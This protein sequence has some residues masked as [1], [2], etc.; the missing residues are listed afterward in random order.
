MARDYAAFY[1]CLSA[2]FRR[3]PHLAAALRVANRV[4]EVIMYGAY[5]VMLTW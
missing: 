3:H 4:V 1:R 5:L 2:P